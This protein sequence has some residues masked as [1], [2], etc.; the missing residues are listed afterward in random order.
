MILVL[1]LD[2]NL[3]KSMRD[4][5]AITDKDKHIIRKMCSVGEVGP[6]VTVLCLNVASQKESGIDIN[7]VKFILYSIGLVENV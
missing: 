2:T 5:E 4:F 3:Y 6:E 1:L 7:Q